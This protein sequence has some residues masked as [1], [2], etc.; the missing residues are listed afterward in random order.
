MI[1]IPAD[2]D[3]G[4]AMKA[5]NERE[6]AFVIHFVMTGGANQA[7]SAFQAGYG[8]GN[9]NNALAVTAH[10]LIR[11]PRILAALKEEAEKSMKTC[12]ILA[13]D[14]LRQIAMD[15]SHRD[16]FKAAVELLNRS[17]LFVE[18]HH[19]VT[20]QDDRRTPE[21]IRQEIVEVFRR[22]FNDRPVPAELEAPIDVECTP[23]LSPLS[24]L[25]NIPDRGEENRA[26]ISSERPWDEGL[27]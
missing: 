4:E 10:R 16:R 1:P 21:E 18:T 8:S 15:P 6:R 17:G 13:T 5:C 25:A 26:L 24:E 14:V 7:E 20:V 2:G 9:S 3:M 12:V 27:D 23:V 11:R 22:V 19:R